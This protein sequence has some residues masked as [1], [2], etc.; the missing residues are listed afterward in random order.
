MPSRLSEAFEEP[1]PPPPQLRSPDVKTAEI[2][3]E[4]LVNLMDQ[5]ILKS[6]AR[7]IKTEGLVGSAKLGSAEGR[8]ARCRERQVVGGRPRVATVF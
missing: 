5:V 2:K 6:G 4:A 7:G 8:L 1:S 3:T